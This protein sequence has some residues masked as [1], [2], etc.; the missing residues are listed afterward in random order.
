MLARPML[1][2][3]LPLGALLACLVISGCSRSAGAP[4]ASA[5]YLFCFWNVENLFDDL[6]Q[7]RGKTD[8]GYDNWFARNPDLLRK[9]LYH[10]AAAMLKLNGG[11]GPDILALV[12]VESPRAADLLRHEL[13]RLLPDETL[14]YQHVVMKEVKLGRHIAP[15]LI[16]RLPVRPGQTRLLGSN[17]RILETHLQVHGQNLVVVTAHWTSRVSDKTGQ[18]RARYADQI[19]GA[20]RAMALANPEVD[21]LLAADCNDPPDADSITQHLH[22]TGDRSAVLHASAGTP[23]FNLF[24]DKSPKDYGTH[25]Y[26]GWKLYD[27]LFISP[28]LLNDQ[29]W[30]C[31]PRSA[32]T[33]NGLYQPSDRTRKPWSFG[34][35]KTLGDRG[36]SDHFPVCV[37]LRVTPR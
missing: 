3:A 37:R 34:G 36:T 28:G 25:Y 30:S 21:Y 18:D 7:A 31:D 23:L 12:E 4:P 24:A 11:R 10:L 17:L 1:L 9:K 13:N 5:S 22:A 15:A 14:H 16:T 19:H 35:E 26:R 32:H 20:Y 8:D 29:G 2:R 33:V 27:S 6:D